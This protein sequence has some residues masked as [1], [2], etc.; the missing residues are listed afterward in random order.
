MH[1]Y[2][3]FNTKW[4]RLSAIDDCFNHCLSSNVYV[5]ACIQK[6]QFNGCRS[7]SRFND[8]EMAKKRGAKLLKIHW[9]MHEIS[10]WTL[11]PMDFVMVG[12]NFQ[13]I[14]CLSAA[15]DS[16]TAFYLNNHFIWGATFH[17]HAIKIKGMRVNS[18]NTS[19]IMA[20]WNWI[21]KWYLTRYN[22]H[23]FLL[24]IHFNS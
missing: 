19:R 12:W 3:A 8:L 22:H 10:N 23:H 1:N 11:N 14:E 16:F 15:N 17:L 24:N 7:F 5:F 13:A 18:G 9:I 4:N 2:N 20:S 6:L 21:N